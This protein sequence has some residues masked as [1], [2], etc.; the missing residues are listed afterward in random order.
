LLQHQTK[1]QIG[2]YFIHKIALLSFPLPA[3]EL[4]KRKHQARS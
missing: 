1:Q 3:F 2:L 4:I